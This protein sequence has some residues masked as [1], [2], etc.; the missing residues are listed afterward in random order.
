MVVAVVV[1]RV[2]HGIDAQPLLEQPPSGE[3][4]AADNFSCLIRNKMGIR[5]FLEDHVSPLPWLVVE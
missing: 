5:A 3:S 4:H 2:N 1:L